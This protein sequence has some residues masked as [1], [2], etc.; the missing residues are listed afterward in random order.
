MN[1]FE[2]IT[3]FAKELSDR[4]SVSEKMVKNE[5]NSFT[6]IQ[7]ELKSMRVF[8]KNE[9]EERE[10]KFTELSKR[11]RGDY[12]QKE[13][14]RLDV[15]Y[16]ESKEKIVEAV[17]EDIRAMVEDKYR[18]LDAMIVSAPTPEQTALLNILNM[19]TGNLTKGE[20]MKILPQFYT[21]YQGMRVLEMIA[22][23]AGYHINVPISGDV[24][25]LYGELDKG[26]RY[27]LEVANDLAKPG[28]PDL[29]YRAF[30]FDNADN[31][32]NCDL[33]YER[34]IQM[35][36]RPAQLIDFAITDALSAA[37]QAEI[38]SLFRGI[39][40]LDPTNA[41]DNI[42]I[43]RNVQEIIKDHPGELE[44]MKRSQYSRY[45]YEAL[46]VQ[47]INENMGREAVITNAEG[48]PEN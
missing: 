18:K 33:A 45:V 35:F 37:E 3:R 2:V 48:A 19:R 14:R 40:G 34:Y 43:L 25:D 7:K 27:L 6:G 16:Q 4:W 44:L 30:Y 15:E 46:D 12:I 28:K 9:R 13:R 10:K 8:L 47:H 29:K 21:N 20:L 5:K 41:G 11:Y 24:M 23:T 22:T 39:D 36:D 1:D 32:G 26:G 31:P 38:N 42:T 17:K